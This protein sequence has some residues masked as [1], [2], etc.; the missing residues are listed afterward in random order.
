[1]GGQHGK[2]ELSKGQQK[3]FTITKAGEEDREVTQKEWR[4]QKLGQ[5]GWNKL[6]DADETADDVADDGTDDDPETVV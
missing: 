1:M 5:L 6:E 2:S 4:E 3:T